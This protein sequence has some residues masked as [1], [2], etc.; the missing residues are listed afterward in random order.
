MVTYISFI[1]SNLTSY[2]I[3]LTN[4][5]HINFMRLMRSLKLRYITQFLYFAS[6]TL[7]ITTM[8]HNHVN[9][10]ETELA[11]LSNSN[12]AWGRTYFFDAPRYK[13]NNVKELLDEAIM[14]KLKS[15]GIQISE[16]DIESKYLLNYTIL[17]G[18]EVGKS[19]F[20]E[21]KFLI[22]IRDRK[23]NSPI[24]R[25]QIEGLANLDNN[26]E[27]KQRIESLVDEIFEPFPLELRPS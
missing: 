16:G 14:N 22:S 27:R 23:T 26:E 12:L 8:M 18:G 3:E 25:N 15:Y 11:N 2:N 17:L 10:E 1:I 4:F 24:W 6:A 20:E 5:I 19:G 9:A 21:G 7:L 13:D